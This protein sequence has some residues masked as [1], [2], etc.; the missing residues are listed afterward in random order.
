MVNLER[1]IDR[2]VLRTR[3]LLRDAFFDLILEKGYEAVTIEDITSRADLG[4]TTFYLHYKDKEDLLMETV[5][6]V[7]SE[8]VSELSE[9][10]L[11]RKR[12]SDG[13]PPDPG[14]VGKAIA[15]AF[16]NVERNSTLYRIIL[17]GEGTYSAVTR[18]REIVIQSISELLQHLVNRDQLAFNPT[19][20][21]EMYLHSLAGAWIWLV[22]WWLEKGKP[23]SPEEMAE[24]FQNMFL[25]SMMAVLGI[26]KR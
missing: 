24:M 1:K 14:L 5:R 10:P 22:G 2:R 16:H 26:S 6:E 4:R 13:E 25:S 8:L 17:R 21:L 15:R 23:F 19:V 3:R 18:L 7:A 12:L 20:P 9:I 11:G